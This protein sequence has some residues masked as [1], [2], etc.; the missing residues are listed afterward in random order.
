[1]K[2][3]PMLKIKDVILFLIAFIVV[4]GGILSI[5][6]SLIPFETEVNRKIEGVYFEKNAA[7]DTVENV[8][9]SISGTYT[10]YVIEWWRDDFY[11]FEFILSDKPHI[12]W[13]GKGILYR[14]DESADFILSDSVSGN[15]QTENGW[16]H[17]HAEVLF[18]NDISKCIITADDG[19]GDVIIYDQYYILPAT[20][21]YE[22]VELFEE[23]TGTGHWIDI[24]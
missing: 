7:S 19:V 24:D 13:M 20:D 3:N 23:L 11:K 15:Y 1:M 8:T 22:A 6:L 16:E 2:N 5:L 14:R 18:D 4:F 10:N 9:I 17:L 12:K 21:I